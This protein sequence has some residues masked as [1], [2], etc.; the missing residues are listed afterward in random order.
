MIPHWRDL[1]GTGR[2]YVKE[3]GSNGMPAASPRTMNRSIVLD[4]MNPP[5]A[6]QS[7]S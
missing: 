7:S 6:S 1:E 4:F 5:K 3:G 2:F